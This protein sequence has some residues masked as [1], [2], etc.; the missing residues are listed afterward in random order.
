MSAN[1]YYLNEYDVVIAFMKNGRIFASGA[2]LA[3]C[4]EYSIT[5]CLI[6]LKPQTLHKESW[7]IAIFWPLCLHFLNNRTESKKFFTQRL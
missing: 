4:T 7:A 5:V 1:V 6:E 3:M 2:G